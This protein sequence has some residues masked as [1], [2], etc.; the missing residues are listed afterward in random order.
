MYKESQQSKLNL[1]SQN[2]TCCGICFEE[3]EA[4]E[5]V[6]NWVQCSVCEIWLHK[7]CIKTEHSLQGFTCD[8]CSSL[9]TQ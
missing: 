4:S 7:K 3:D 2:T 6:I 1:I 5:E 8:M 9:A